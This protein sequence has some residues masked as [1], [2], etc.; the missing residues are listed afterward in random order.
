MV[1]TAE[2]NNLKVGDIVK[3][4]VVVARVIVGE[5]N[6]IAV[7]ITTKRYSEDDYHIGLEFKKD[8]NE[9]HNLDNKI[10]SFRGRYT[11]NPL[12]IIEILNKKEITIEKYLKIKKEKYI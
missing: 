5:D 8:F 10:S 11:T 1:T 12:D 9:G 4:R 7:V 2:F 3:T 6:T